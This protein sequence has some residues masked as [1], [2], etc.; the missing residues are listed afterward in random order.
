[1]TNRQTDKQTDR[2][3]DISY[4]KDN[5][6]IDTDTYPYEAKDY[7]KFIKERNRLTD[8]Q[9]YFMSNRKVLMQ[10]KKKIERKIK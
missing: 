2:Q 3:T 5:Q 9:T 7:N 4:V 8:R 1:M 6:F 10:K